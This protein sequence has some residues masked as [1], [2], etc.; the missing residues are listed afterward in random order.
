MRI[1]TEGKKNGSWNLL[2][3]VEALV[4]PTDLQI[5]FEKEPKAFEF[6]SALSKTNKKN[7]LLWM[8][9]AKLP[10]TRIKRISTIIE[11][12]LLNKKPPHM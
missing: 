6:Y 12:A 3:D 10:E 5:A 4:I 8:V 2:D 7:I 9:M 11:C 1:C